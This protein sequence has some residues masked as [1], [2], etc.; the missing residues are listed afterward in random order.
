MSEKSI[1]K[2]FKDLNIAD[3]EKSD[4]KILPK[5]SRKIKS[6][7]SF[8]E[9]KKLKSIVN[10]NNIPYLNRISSSKFETIMSEIKLK[11]R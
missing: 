11:R 10:S 2:I 5:N 4:I 7:L 9:Q 3:I 1:D 6:I 8:K